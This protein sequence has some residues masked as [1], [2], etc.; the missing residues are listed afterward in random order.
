MSCQVRKAFSAFPAA[1]L[2][3]PSHTRFGPR[4]SFLSSR[5]ARPPGPPASGSWYSGR[6]MPAPG[7]VFLT[8]KVTKDT[9][10]LENH[11]R[12]KT[13]EARS[14]QRSLGIMNAA[15]GTQLAG[16]PRTPYIETL[17]DLCVFVV[18]PFVPTRQPERRTAPPTP[19]PLLNQHLCVLCAL[20]G[21]F[22]L[23][24]RYKPNA[25]PPHQRRNLFEIDLFVPSV[26]PWFHPLCAPFSPAA[27]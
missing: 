17:C 6:D 8:T 19:E 18:N 14:T 15:T 23:C 24:P 3:L 26:A 4:I 9:K 16:P 7:V 13:T 11:V 12:G 5:L 21:V 1:C 10:I 27:G 2:C 25:I 22:P 20:C